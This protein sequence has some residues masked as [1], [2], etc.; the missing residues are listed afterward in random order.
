MANVPLVD[1]GWQRD[2][3]ADDVEAGF[4]RVLEKT[5]FINGPDVGAFEEE[6]ARYSG[7][8]H[9]VGVGN[10][11]DAIELGLRALGITDGEVVI[12]A[13]TFIATAEAVVRAGATPVLVDQDEAS[14]L[15]DT[16]QAAAAIND[17]T[18]AIIGVHLYGQ[19]RAARAARRRGRRYR[20]RAV[21]GRG[22]S[23]GRD[24]ARGAGSVRSLES[25]PP[26]STPVRI[27]VP[28]ETPVRSSPVT[29]RSQGS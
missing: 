7:V 27:S 11:T 16:D 26:A 19:I 14:Y 6:F 29:T 10:G 13:N 1:L 21:R 15:I 24:P 28:T 4:E 18:R 2:Q 12:P 25:R 5:A 8:A 20:R 3:I 17:R 23:T 22:P 9:C